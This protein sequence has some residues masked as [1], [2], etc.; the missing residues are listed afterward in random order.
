MP[1]R[2]APLLKRVVFA[3]VAG[4]GHR[5]VAELL[6]SLPG[7]VLVAEVGTTEALAREMRSSNPD[8]LV[9]DDRLVAALGSGPRDA[10]VAVIVVGVDDDP[11]FAH[12][13]RSVGAIAWIPKER[14]DELL[15][16]ALERVQR[17][18]DAERPPGS[19]R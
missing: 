5:A 10:S 8:V 13:A 6:R 12:R 16:A 15:P 2:P 3:D 17:T 4:A 19:A 14:A 11:S 1:L 9:V 18:G 7:I